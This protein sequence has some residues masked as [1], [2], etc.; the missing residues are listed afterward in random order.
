MFFFPQKMRVSLLLTILCHFSSSRELPFFSSSN[1]MVS[2]VT[3]FNTIYTI[4]SK[5]FKIKSSILKIRGGQNPNNG[6]ETILRNSMRRGGASSKSKPTSVRGQKNR[7]S[8]LNV[9][10][11]P[12][13]TEI[14]VELVKTRRK[15]LEN[16]QIKEKIDNWI[17]A[18]KYK[19][20]FVPRKEYV[21]TFALDAVES[22]SIPKKKNRKV[23]SFDAALFFTY[24]CS[25]FTITA[26]VVLIPIIAG[27]PS[28]YD[29]KLAMF[30]SV[31]GASFA[32]AIASISTIGAAAG[33]VVNGFVCQIL[34]SRRSLM[35]YLVGLSIFTTWFA[36][37]Q[38]IDQLA[39]S[40]L[41]MEFFAS[42]MWTASVVLLATH[43]EKEPKHF[44]V[45]VGYLSLSSTVA[46][47]IAKFGLSFLLT[48]MDW[49]ILAK[50]TAGV[51]LL[52]AFVVYQLVSD[53]PTQTVQPQEKEL[54]IKSIGSSFKRVTTYPLFWKMGIAHSAVFLVRTS[55]K[56][57][58]SF[59]NQV[60]DLP[61]SL[62]GG[63]TSS[64]TIGFAL[65]AILH[66]PRINSLVKFNEKK[67][68]Y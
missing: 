56:V 60:T 48:M 25:M 15:T 22:T 37:S 68:T 4:P 7:E 58:G 27:D 24:V 11:S 53:S 17:N 28:M 47:L 8:Y 66:T 44:A 26:P 1:S 64:V 3:G 9:L 40:I 39:F 13:Y 29:S 23:R 54:S 10:S 36:K 41:G 42:I 61:R 63:F 30:S 55:D 49:R 50:L 59:F 62:C 14:E 18:E 52:G 67:K 34:G 35:F 51:S 57:L 6:E 45:S 46:S 12:M 31:S 38:N 21:R 16:N 19:S 5:S 65:G 20:M 33:K 2:V 32:A 43:Y